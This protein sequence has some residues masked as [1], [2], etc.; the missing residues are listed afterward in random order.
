MT[1]ELDWY[2]RYTTVCL[3]LKN[4]S[5]NRFFTCYCFL[6]GTGVGYALDVAYMYIVNREVC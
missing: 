1:T 4:L 6:L 2:D 3:P 5:E